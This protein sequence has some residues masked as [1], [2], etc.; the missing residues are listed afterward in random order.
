MLRSKPG[1]GGPRSR[2]VF[3]VGAAI[4]ALGFG[5]WASGCVKTSLKDSVLPP[6]PPRVAKASAVGTAACADCHPAEVEFYGAS[7]HKIAFLAGPKRD[8][9]ESCHGN[10]SEHIAY[11]EENGEYE[12]E[13]DDLV[14]KDALGTATASQRSALCQ[15]CHQADFPLWPTTD[16]ARADVSCW[17]CHSGDL[18]DPPVDVARFGPA[19]L[20]SKRD[21]EFCF[22]CH[23]NV[24]LD[25]ELQFHHRVPEG[26]MRC[27]D[28]HSIHGAARENPVV[29]TRNTECLSCHP[30]VGGP[31]VFEHVGTQ[32]GCE[33]CHDPHGS[34]NNKLLISNTNSL[35]IQCHVQ[36]SVG[37]F[38]RQPHAQFLMG[39]AL[40][41]DCHVQVHGSNSDRNLNP[42]R[43]Q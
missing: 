5:A 38:G 11:F 26:Q 36:Q 35:C 7:R 13:V 37:F 32:E 25:F 41:Y 34:I 20:D 33:V 24:R 3:V 6:L 2:W 31:W 14:G 15:Q 39:G 43:F 4:V 27:A 12:G 19:A 16:H 42:R 8:G 21:D 28:C 10:G 40:C 17:D 9:C 1:S 18:H 23:E 29:Q 22:Q 30:E